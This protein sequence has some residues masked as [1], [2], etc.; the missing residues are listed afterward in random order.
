MVHSPT[1]YPTNALPGSIQVIPGLYGDMYSATGV[2]GCPQVCKKINSS[3]L[4]D[5][6]SKFLTHRKLQVLFEWMKTTVSISR[7]A[8][9]ITEVEDVGAVAPET[10]NVDLNS[11][12]GPTFQQKFMNL[13]LSQ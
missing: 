8:G 1:I 11:F 9:N 10:R 7:L 4:D 12:H 5:I 2:T 13:L 3:C 6:R